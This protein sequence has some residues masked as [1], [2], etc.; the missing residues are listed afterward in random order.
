MLRHRVKQEFGIP[1]SAP[2]STKKQS[3]IL[4]KLNLN[5]YL[6]RCAE[7]HQ[8]RVESASCPI[9]TIRNR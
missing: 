9:I 3:R 8:R 5:T 4:Y 2:E 1:H 6:M 7:L